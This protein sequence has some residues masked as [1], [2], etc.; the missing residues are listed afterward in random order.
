[1]V[2]GHEDIG[3]SR[4]ASDVTRADFQDLAQ[5]WPFRQVFID[6]ALNFT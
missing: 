1:M 3:G 5:P 2:A 4:K 6:L